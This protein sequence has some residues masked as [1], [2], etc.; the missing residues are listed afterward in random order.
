M[1]PGAMF[2]V[3]AV[4]VVVV[5]VVVVFVVVVAVVVVAVVVV[6]VVVVVVVAVVVVAAVSIDSLVDYFL[7]S[8]I[9]KK[10]FHFFFCLILKNAHCHKNC[11]M[12]E[13]NVFY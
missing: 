2:V 6:A 9:K 13:Y 1:L 12:K 10:M 4:V 7:Y 8:K 11:K 5:A 3:L